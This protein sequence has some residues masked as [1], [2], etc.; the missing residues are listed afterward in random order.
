[1]APRPGIAG[2]LA[3]ITGDEHVLDDPDTAAS[4]CTDWT[5]RFVGATPAVVRPGDVAEVAAVLSV[6]GE[7]GV[8]VVPQGGNTGL[9]G[10]SVPLHGEV[11]LSLRRLAGVDEVDRLAAQM[12][13]GA[14]ASLADVQRAAAAADL[15][16]PIDLTARDSATIGGTV[17]TNAGGLHVLRYGTTRSQVLGVEA[18]LADGRVLRHLGGLV[19]DNTGYD[20]AGLLCGSEGTLA[21]VTAARLRLVPSLPERVTALLAFDTVG[22]AVQAAGA[23]RDSVSSLVAIELFCGDGL[24]LVCETTGAGP[25][26]PVAYDAFL[27]VEGAAQVDPAAEL[28]EATSGLEGVRAVAVA[29]DEPQRRRL[30][31]YREAHTAAIERLGVPHKLDVALPMSNIA[32]FLGVVGSRV[33]EVAPEATTIVFGHVADGN[34]HVNVVGVA[35]DDDRVDDAVLGLVVDRGGS[36]SAE[37][38]IGTAKRRWLHLSRSEAE[39]DSYRAIKR[40]LDPEGILNPNVLIPPTTARDGT[41]RP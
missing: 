34:L 4:F 35:P 39:I 27:L 10:G 29:V 28:S 17:A 7:S 20:L 18:V 37:H 38:G 25:P 19:K 33:L 9:V 21:V 8:A 30:W 32:D 2:R 6:C 5:G 22:S 31:H 41:G 23:L 16:Y 15:S 24:E 3:E 1:M 36:I 14:G 11:V 12:T 26:F 13:V 40:A